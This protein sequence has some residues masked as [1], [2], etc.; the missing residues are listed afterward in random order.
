MA[1]KIG[2]RIVS[3]RKIMFDK[4][5]DM[6]ILP[7]QD[8]NLGVLAGHTPLTTGLSVGILRIFEDDKETNIAVHGGFVEVNPK[9][10]TLIT[11]NA[12]WGKDID[13]ARA[14]ASKERAEKRLSEN[15]ENTDVAR[16]SLSLK[17]AL[18]RIDI[19]SKI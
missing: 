5:I 10:I 13:V 17:K 2:L 19:A 12:E 7:A 15:N 6:V 11:D 18:T 4:E 8:G 9:L 14:K 1:N 3:P 16:A